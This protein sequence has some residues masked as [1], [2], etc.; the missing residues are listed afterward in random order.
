MQAGEPTPLLPTVLQVLGGTL[1]MPAPSSCCPLG[2]ESA[3]QE[4]VA[5]SSFFGDK[6]AA[7]LEASQS[8]VRK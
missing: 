2:C 8:G 5:I 3:K 4:A 1:A 7:L 6:V